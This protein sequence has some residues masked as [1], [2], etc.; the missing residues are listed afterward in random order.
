MKEIVLVITGGA[1]GSLLRFLCGKYV[2]AGLQI[3]GL[4]NPAVLIVNMA[5]SFTI[6]C[7]LALMQGK[8]GTGLYIFLTTG[9][10]G[11]FTT[12]SAFSGEMLQ[13][14]QKNEIGNSIIYALITFIA[15]LGFTWIG[16]KIFS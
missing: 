12:F 4:L 10:L 15:G 16:Y 1:T 6:G 3:F 9:F 5:G 13:L 8:S 2:F 11:G 14:I 7:I